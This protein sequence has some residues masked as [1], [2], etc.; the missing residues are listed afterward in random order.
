M[1]GGN[2]NNKV[3]PVAGTNGMTLVLTGM[4]KGGSVTIR[5]PRQGMFSH[6]F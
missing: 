1:R 2:I 3:A 5:H 4:K 6:W